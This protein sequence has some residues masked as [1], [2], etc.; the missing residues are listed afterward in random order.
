M[1]SG[2]KMSIVIKSCSAFGLLLTV[3]IAL[4]M[5]PSLASVSESGDDQPR[6]HILDIRLKWDQEDTP[7]KEQTEDRPLVLLPSIIRVRF[8]PE[9]PHERQVAEIFDLRR[10]NRFSTP[11]GITSLGERLR[12]NER[13]LGCF[14]LECQALCCPLQRRGCYGRCQLMTGN[15]LCYG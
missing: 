6:V 15:C 3:S 12:S 8:A 5:T 13:R 7:Q 11:R 14:D 10:M 4:A 2:F 9:I 1:L